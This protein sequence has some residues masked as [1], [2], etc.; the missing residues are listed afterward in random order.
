[1][2]SLF[3]KENCRCINIINFC[4]KS[5]YNSDNKVCVFKDLGGDRMRLILNLIQTEYTY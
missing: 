1:M 5:N 2:F 4:K 3:Y